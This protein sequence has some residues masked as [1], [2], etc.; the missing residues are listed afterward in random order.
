MASAPARSR[1]PSARPSSRRAAMPGPTV[2]SSSRRDRSTM[3]ARSRARRPVA[4]AARRRSCS[5]PR[6]PSPTWSS[7][8]TGRRARP[9]IGAIE[10]ATAAGERV[11]ALAAG[12]A[13]GAARM[14]ALIGFADPLRPGIREATTPRSAGRH[15]GRDRDRGP[16][17]DGGG[18]RATGGLGDG[19][20]GPRTRGRGLV[21]RGAG[22]RL[23]CH[24]GRRPIHTGTEAPDR[25]GR[26][27]SRP[28]RR[29]HRR[30]RQRRPGAPRRRRRR[31][32]GQRD[33]RRQGGLGP[34]P[35]R[36]LVRDARLRHPR[37]S[38]HRRQRAEGPGVPRLD[39]RRAARL[40]LHRDGRRLRPAAP[41]DPDPVA[42]A[43][44]RRGG[45]GR[46][47][48]RASRAGLMS[49]P[50]RPV[51]EPLLT[52]G[53]LGQDRGRRGLQRQLPRCG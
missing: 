42:R 6:R 22:D 26:P 49:R 18:D 1:P 8:R 53:L 9:G 37:G 2:G 11:V 31:G 7:A 40:H 34:G 24:H 30:R 4:M 10:A 16:P 47:R 20:R 44:H 45:V 14:V 33:G 12:E 46:L 15:P 35:R 32:D 29:G 13:D 23:A 19:V 39:P 52:R 21:G 25:P 28:P 38:A 17:D 3:I 5:V 27:G 43:V 51:G 41:A 48:T 50:P 36:R